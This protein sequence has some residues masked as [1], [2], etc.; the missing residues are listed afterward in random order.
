MF[1]ALVP[2]DSEYFC[3]VPLIPQYVYR[4]SP[5]LFACFTIHSRKKSS[6]NRHF[7]LLEIRSCCTLSAA[8]YVISTVSAASATVTTSM[9]W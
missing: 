1:L 7:I 5:C 9:V 3:G 8:V 4:C 2:P 6:S